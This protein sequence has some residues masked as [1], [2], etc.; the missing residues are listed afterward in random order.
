MIS[1]IWVPLICSQIRLSGLVKH[2]SSNWLTVI[3]CPVIVPRR[4]TRQ[5]QCQKAAL[6]YNRACWV[7]CFQYTAFSNCSSMSSFVSWWSSLHLSFLEK[8]P[9]L[10]SSCRTLAVETGLSSTLGRVTSHWEGEEGNLWVL[11]LCTQGC[12]RVTPPLDLKWNWW[13]INPV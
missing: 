5:V 1:L 10:A 6:C 2:F 3:Y 12:K 8:F 4:C 13:N 9:A 11:S 7:G